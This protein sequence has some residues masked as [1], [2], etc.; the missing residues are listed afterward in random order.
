MVFSPIVLQN[1]Q[2]LS[3]I[4]R[5]NRVDIFSLDGDMSN[6]RLSPIPYICFESKLFWPL[7]QCRPTAREGYG[8]NGNGMVS[9][10]VFKCTY[11]LHRILDP[12]SLQKAA[13]QLKI[14]EENGNKV[15]SKI[16]AKQARL[17]NLR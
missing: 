8:E 1:P 11:Y 12:C 2:T 16:R 7:E 6:V 15:S 14:R 3:P 13:C 17:C 10:E 5:V 9:F 4:G